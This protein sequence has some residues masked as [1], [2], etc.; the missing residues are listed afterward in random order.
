MAYGVLCEHAPPVIDLRRLS[1]TAVEPVSPRLG[2]AQLARQ[3]FVIGKK[4]FVI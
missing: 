3:G 1:E 2:R 4:H